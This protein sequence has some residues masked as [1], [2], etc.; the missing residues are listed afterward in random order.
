MDERPPDI[1]II[2]GGDPVDRSVVAD[3][4]SVGTLL[5][6]ADSGLDV[7][8]R[9]GWADEVDIVVGDFDSVSHAAL[10]RATI[11]GADIRPHPPNKDWTDLELALAVAA[12]HHG[13]ESPSVLVIGATGG[14]FDHELANLLVLA[15]PVFSSL[16]IAWRH[17]GGVGW[18][19]RSR[20]SVPV[21]P[22]ATVS[23]LPVH[24]PATVSLVGFNWPL[25]RRV[26]QPGSTL[27]VSNVAITNG[28]AVTVHD[29]VAL[30][31]APVSNHMEN[32]R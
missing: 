9:I 12:E 26:I 20:L 16:D 7:A 29:G 17:D 5:I 4:D 32:L 3:V 22:P 25:E 28:P 8:T 10:D 15:S 19:V 14:R 27:G 30:V 23:V 6:A 21:E 24:G 31:L 18:V 13:D 1:V 11:R 2:A